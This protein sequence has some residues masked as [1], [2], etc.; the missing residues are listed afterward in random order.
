MFSFISSSLYPS[1]ASGDIFFWKKK[2]PFENLPDAFKKR[3]SHLILENNLYAF[4]KICPAATEL[5]YHRIERFDQVFITDN[6]AIHNLASDRVL[7]YRRYKW[8]YKY[9]RFFID[10]VLY[11]SAIL[12]DKNYFTATWHSVLSVDNIVKK[13]R[14]LYVEDTLVLHC[15]TIESYGDIIP[16]ITGSYTRLVLCGN[17][18]WA[19]AKQLITLNVEKVHIYAK[20]RITSE[21]Y[22]DFVEFVMQY[23]RGFHSMFAFFYKISELRAQ[24]YN[25]CQQHNTHEFQPYS[26]FWVV[27]QRGYY[28]YCLT[29]W[30]RIKTVQSFLIVILK[31]RG[32]FLAALV[33]ECY[34]TMENLAAKLRKPNHLQINVNKMS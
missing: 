4:R 28:S 12:G 18:T 11:F 32:W 33:P 1:I 8:L 21:E 15:D 2:L 13:N 10:G 30:H 3:L 9:L 6:D 24:V 22:D 20:V 34:V 26:F 16:R 29:I 25:A 7:F 27:T 31:L 23:V 19:Q 5:C 14:K 17:I